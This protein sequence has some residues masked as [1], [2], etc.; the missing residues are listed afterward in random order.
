MSSGTRRSCTLFMAAIVVG[1][2]LPVAAFAPPVRAADPPYTGFIIDSETGNPF[3]G[4]SAHDHYPST[5]TGAGTPTNFLLSGPEWSFHFVD[6]SPLTEREYFDGVLQFSVLRN[7][8]SCSSSDWTLRVWEAPQ[9]VDGS[10]TRFAADFWRNRCGAGDTRAAMYGTLRIGSSIPP[11]I[12]HVTSRLDFP[13]TF[14]GESAST[15]TITVENLGEATIDA[16]PVVASGPHLTDFPVDDGCGVVSLDPGQQCTITVGF[17]PSTSTSRNAALTLTST[18]YGPARTIDLEGYGLSQLI[19]TP[20]ALVIDTRPGGFG[21]SW[22]DQYLDPVEMTATGDYQDVTLNAAEWRITFQA[23]DE[24]PLVVGTYEHVVW[25]GLV[26]SRGGSACVPLDA[27]FTILEAPVIDTDGTIL[28]F[29]GDFTVTCDSSD[30]MPIDGWVRFHSDHDRPLVQPPVSY[31]IEVSTGTSGHIGE[32]ITITPR[33]AGTDRLDAHRCRMGIESGDLANLVRMQVAA[34]SCEPWTL[35]IPAA[36]LGDY[37]VFGSLITQEEGQI[38]WTEAAEQSLSITGGTPVPFTSNYPVQSWAAADLLSDPTPAFGQSLTVKPPA[39]LDGC[40]LRVV[41]GMELAQ[42]SQD[43]GCTPWTLSLAAPTPDVVATFFGDRADARIIGWVGTSTW[44]ETNPELPYLGAIWSETYSSAMA[45]FTGTGGSYASNIPAIFSGAARGNVYYTDDPTTHQYAPVVKG[46]LSG[47]CTSDRQPLSVPVVDGTCAAF[48]VPPTDL[49][50]NVSA[51]VSFQL[52]DTDGDLVAEAETGIGFV[53]RMAPL[54]LSAPSEVQ[55]GTAIPVQASTSDGAP[56]TYEVQLTP[57]AASTSVGIASTTTSTTYRGTFQPTLGSP[58]DAIALNVTGLAAGSWDVRATFID[59]L[60]GAATATKRIKV[61]D[62]TPPSGSVTIA[63]GASYTKVTAV[64][65]ATAATDT[66]TGLD[67]VKLSNDGTNWTSRPYAA[68]QAWTLP[69]TN[70]TRTVYVKWVD[71][72]GNISAVKTDTIVLDTVAPTATAPRRGFVASSSISAGRIALRVPWSGSDATSGI[73]RY[74]LAQSTDGGAWTTVSTTL[75]S[76]TATRNLA[77]LHTYRF[78]VRAVDKAG[79]PGSWAT[80]TTFRISRYSESNAAI[81]Y[82]GSWTKVSSTAY[83]GSAAKKSSTAGAKASLTFSGRSIAWVA[84]TG[85]D[86]GKAGIYVNGTKVATV[87]LYSPTAQA[88]RV[89]WVGS[90]TTTASRTVTIRVAGT[91]GR[92]RI[93]LDALVTAN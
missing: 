10:V 86:R 5:F 55:I 88:Q 34:D 31:S 8:L 52:L 2:M 71:K 45:T 54:A 33:V 42:T 72:A 69:A 82:S 32:T 58:G 6:S 65:V 4:G 24:G 40:V 93:D 3:G 14:A 30:G 68:S 80:G 60:G 7:G 90:W 35:T 83:W 9:I 70:G 63:G 15:Q 16:Q 37:R 49:T 20:S 77:P 62:T 26:V 64:T 66:G 12:L 46:A 51:S 27:A 17:D 92:P 19:K 48:S 44:S 87:D 79:N 39:G 84:R 1:L 28:R 38:E 36:S 43:A 11:S 74:E 13:D 67:F 57:V 81:T 18:A 22:G 47:T 25:P 76:P 56:A 91:V 85:P 21:G 41:G 75:T 29:A 89:V 73:A 50:G 78:R 59:V 61:L 53:D 23:A